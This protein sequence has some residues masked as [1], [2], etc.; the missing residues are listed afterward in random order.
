MISRLEPGQSYRFRVYSLNAEGVPGPKSERQVQY[1]TYLNIFII[2]SYYSVVVHTML[3][4]PPNPSVAPSGLGTTSLNLT[5]KP[6]VQFQSTRNKQVVNRML[7]DWAGTH[8][9]EDKGVS[10]EAAFAK[11]D[12]DGSGDIDS[13]E[14][15]LMLSDLGVQVTEERIRQAIDT[16]DINGDGKISF[17]EFG[18]WWRADDVI[19]TLK[20]SEAIVSS[21]R[22]S[23]L[24]AGIRS[25]IQGKDQSILNDDSNQPA[26]AFGL[27]MIPEET[28]TLEISGL[29]PS[30]IGSNSI[31]PK[32]AP[33]SRGQSNSIELTS[34]A[35]QQD[36]VLTK[37][38]PVPIISYR[39]PQTKVTISGLE[40]NRLYHFKLRY[41]GSRSNSMISKPLV[42]MTLP[43]PPTQPIL[44]ILASMMVR[45]KWYPSQYGAFKFSVQII[46]AIP[47]SVTRKGLSNAT[48]DLSDGWTTVFTGQETTWTSTTLAPE[49]N[50][51]LRVVAINCQGS[52]SAPSPE[53]SFTTPHRNE[54]SK[55][56]LSPK[57]LDSTFSIE[58]TNDICVGD[59][60]IITERLYAKSK[61]ESITSE[62]NAKAKSATARDMRASTTS[63]M[64]VASLL[65]DG[66]PE[67]SGTFI[68]ERTIAAHVIKDNYKTV[69]DIL[70]VNG[71]PKGFTSGQ[72][73]A[74]ISKHRRLWLEVVWQ[75][76][77]S[78]ACKP[79]E[80]KAGDII[81]RQQSKL[82]SYEVFR[83]PWTQEEQRIP[84]L[85]EWISLNECYIA[86]DC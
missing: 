83:C 24:R 65:S 15:A 84:L 31:R 27:S 51:R 48:F 28:N 66:K 61:S 69:R 8:L 33:R 9:E 44:A 4:T 45:V 62:V 40:P 79:Y 11:Y 23:T 70:Q 59:T 16:L 19:Y 80:M 81:E 72:L 75:K 13:S 32:S 26:R 34:P 37:D 52:M 67:S 77:K 85:K 71:D 47:V 53:I 49:T 22:T 5:W 63:M 60:I 1:Q 6:R 3:E 42:I 50:Y 46:K 38:V 17:E 12:R 30:K 64:S 7:G 76:S 36:V 86:M 82:E 56:F 20:R 43:L 78:P 41:I 18:K 68:G 2:L 25:F 55:D 21:I 10:I 54:T 29:V 73:S 35:P 74:N 39:G 14:I 57:A 58:C